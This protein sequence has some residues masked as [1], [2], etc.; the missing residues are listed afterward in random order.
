MNDKRLAQLI[1]MQKADPNDPFFLYAIGLEHVKAS[2]FSEANR[3]FQDII[4]SFPS[5]L[6]TYYQ[7]ALLLVQTNDLNGAIGSLEAGIE[8]ARAS[9]ENKTLR[10]LESLMEDIEDEL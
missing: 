3:V 10:E 4:S 7:H 8:V 6:P 1:E 5:Y 9:G 2:N